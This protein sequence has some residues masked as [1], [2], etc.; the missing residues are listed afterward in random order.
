MTDR[1]SLVNASPSAELSPPPKRR[2]LRKGT[3]S[4]WECKRRK[5]RCRFSALT[6]HVCEGCKRRGT[7]CVSQELTDQPPPPGSN[8]QMM[9][10]LGQ[11]EALVGQLLNSVDTSSRAARLVPSTP[12]LRDQRSRSRSPATRIYSSRHSRERPALTRAASRSESNASAKPA[13]DALSRDLLAAWPSPEGME[14][15]LGM[16]VETSSIIRGVTCTQPTTPSGLMLPSARTLLQLPPTGSHPVLIAQKMLILGTFLQ[17]MPFSSARQLESRGLD[18]CEIMTRLVET[19]HDLVT[20]KDQLVGSI[21]G[22]E[23]IMLES[24]YENYAG[25]LRPSWLAARRA[26]TIAQMLGLHRGVNPP[27]LTGG[28]IEPGYLW[29]RLIQL[30]RYLS[31]VLGLPQSS[32]EDSF[33]SQH[34]LES[35]TALERMHR[36]ACVATGRILRR[37]S[38]EIDN[39]MTTE[40]IDKLLQ[41]ASATMPAQWWIA[42]SFA[43]CSGHMEMIRETLRFSDHFMLYHLLVQLHLPYLLRSGAEPEYAYNR[44]TVV[45]TSREILS[46]LVTF[47]SFHLIGHYC[48]GIDILTFISST[49]LCLAHIRDNEGHRSEESGLYLQTHQRLTD[50][51]LLE[52]TLENM[53]DMVTLRNN[54]IAVRVATLLEYLLAIE[55]DVSTGG[56]YTIV[57]S[58]ESTRED[59]LGCRA[60]LSDDGGILSIHLPHFSVI[61]IERRPPQTKTLQASRIPGYTQ[62]V[63]RQEWRRE[64]QSH[65]AV[66]ETELQSPSR[67]STWQDL[68]LPQLSPTALGNEPESS[69]GQWTSTQ[70]TIFSDRYNAVDDWTVQDIDLAFLDGLLHEGE[71]MR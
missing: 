5:A 50:R 69:R 8:K 49:A 21:E 6:Q 27:S 4:C 55:E 45:T 70:D 46:R 10:R 32:P 64:K 9:D 59:D 57:V 41:S 48:C 42:P 63:N 22:I 16:P 14:I 25:N 29:F 1:A 12:R 43:S 51:G 26:V 30:D 15:I 3:Q 52:R 62:N 33:A 66:R 24:L 36:L 13:H 18:S 28:I 71:E 40:E 11:V 31:L 61:K 60:H 44:M 19:A 56:S 68:S 35:C 39:S 37:H 58:P 2:K 7:D 20:S 23:C 34:D 38:S 65:V 67:S 53:Q 54:T 17:G 47:R